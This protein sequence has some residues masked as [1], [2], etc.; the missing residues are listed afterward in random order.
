L[1]NSASS[2]LRSLRNHLCASLQG[3]SRLT[4]ISAEV[5]MGNI[6]VA[7]YARTLTMLRTSLTY[8]PHH[9]STPQQRQQRG[10]GIT[11]DGSNNESLPAPPEE[12]VPSAVLAVA[13]KGLDIWYDDD[14][15]SFP[16]AT[17]THLRFSS[18]AAALHSQQLH[19]CKRAKVGALK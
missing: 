10:A 7:L 9:T 19:G 11:A 12:Q 5:Q 15:P 3:D 2:A 4:G 8:A 17:N 16:D 14:Q 13:A 18:G 1:H 6:A